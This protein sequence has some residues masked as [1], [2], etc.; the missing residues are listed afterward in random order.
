MKLLR[1]TDA[2]ASGGRLHIRF[3]AKVIDLYGKVQYWHY[4]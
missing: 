4:N 2:P 3:I 1:P